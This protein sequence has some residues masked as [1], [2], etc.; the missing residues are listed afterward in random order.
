MR[1]AVLG[2]GSWGTAL[3]KIV[4]DN[5]HDVTLWGRRPELAAQIQESRENT[6]FLPGARLPDTLRATSDLGEAL[7][8]ASMLVVAVPTHGIRETLR[9]CE[10]LIPR[11]IPVVSAT[12]G[13]EQDSLYF[14][15]EMLADEVAW[16]KDSFVALSGPSFAREVA[17]GLPTVVVAAARDLTLA[18]E[19]QRAFWTDNRFRVYL[20]D[21]VVGVEIGGALKNVIAIAAGASDGLGFG[22]NA[23]AAL[24]TR[25]LA[26]IARLAMKMG[27]DALTLAGLAGMG[28]LVLTCTGDLSRNRY[29]GFELGKGRSLSEV[30]GGMRQVAE[31]VRT[32]KSAFDLSRR[33]GVFM[34]IIEQVHA[35]LYEEKNL[36]EAVHALMTREAGHER[37]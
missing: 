3:A 6:T 11:G 16:T 5:G 35:T 9:K 33:E 12:K 18:R 37:D 30:L 15:N 24:I 7:H 32:S 36:R 25:G 31:G 22:H 17:A 27:G 1:I 26:E 29:V 21:D 13:I 8:G 2:S 19:V 20:S 4:A 34:P 23:R 10:A 28:D 14:V